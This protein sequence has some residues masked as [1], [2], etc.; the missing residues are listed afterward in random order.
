MS[1]T[2]FCLLNVTRKR[3]NKFECNS[4][5]DVNDE[6][7]SDFI[8]LDACIRNIECAI[9]NKQNNSNDCLF[10]K[11]AKEYFSNKPSDCQQCKTCY[12]NP[13]LTFNRISVPMSLKK[14]SEMTPEERKKHSMIH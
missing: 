14:P 4:N 13:S 1:I 12:L 2:E 11:F 9:I 8:D 5:E 7:Y 6:R 3:L 10:C